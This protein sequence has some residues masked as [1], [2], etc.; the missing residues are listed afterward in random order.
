MLYRFKHD[1][2]NDP[3]IFEDNRLRPRSYFIPFSSREACDKCDY[4]NE[5][6]SSDCVQVL[7][8]EWDFVYYSK[9][10]DM[11]DK[12]DFYDLKTDKVQVPSCWQY[13]GYESP[14]YVNVRYQFDYKFP[15]V[16]ADE[17]TVG[18]NMP[19]NDGKIHK[20][21]NSIGV[22]RRR[23]EAK[24]GFKNFLTFLGAA[25]NVQVYLN[26]RY[27][28]YGEG[29]HN[30]SEFDVTQFML[31]GE[32]ELVVLVYKW[33]SGTYLESQDMF[34][35]NGIFRDVYLTTHYGAYIWDI[36]TSVSRKGAVWTLSAEADV[37]GENTSLEYVLERAGR[38]IA[39]VKA[40]AGKASFEIEQP[41]L[42][43]AE[44]PALYMLYA[45]LKKGSKTVE[46]IRQEVGFKEIA[47][48]GNVYLF[49]GKPI[50][51]KGVN[52]HDTDESKGYVMNAFDYLKDAMLMKEYNV[53]AV[54][55]SHYPPDPV[56]I[57]IA[58][59]IGLYIIDEAD[60]ETHGASARKNFYTPNAI[61]N[62]TPWKDF[63][64]DRVY[65]MYERDKNNPCVSMWSLGN[66][67]GGWRNQ[68]YC[69]AKLK[70]LTPIPIHYE[71]VVRTKR[72][73]Y[74][75][76]SEM[77]PS[78]EFIDKYADGTAPKKYYE[79]PY[80]MCEYAHAMG[81][82]PGS[83]DRY[84]QDIY[85]TRSAMGG[86]IW[87]WCD[88]AVKH[89]DGTYTYGGD[90]GEYDHD[91]NFC[92]DGLF[93][94]NRE[95]HTGARLMQA[96]YRPV[97]AAYVSSN[98]Y[99]LTN[100]NRFA[101][102]SYIDIAWQYSVDGAVC[103]SGRI[104]RIIAPA[105]TEEVELK[106]RAIDT[107]K[108]CCITFVYTD[109]NTGKTIAK[110]QIMM[111][112]SMMQLR[113]PAEK[114]DLA[115][116]ES[117]DDISVVTNTGRIKINK[118]DG[119]VESWVTAG[120]ELLN[121]NAEQKGF[122]LSL[123]GAP[124]DNYM[125]VDWHWKKAGFD[126]YKV[127]FVGMDSEKT[128]GRVVIAC[129]YKVMMKGRE[130]FGFIL[131]YTVRADNS[132]DV[133]TLLEPKKKYDLPKFG[134]TIEMPSA[135]DRVRYYGRGEY[136]NYPDMN[137]HAVLGI[138]KVSV[139]RMYENYIKPQESGSRGDTR[140]AEVT[141]ES[142]AGLR[143]IAEEK[144]FAFYAVPYTFKGI[145]GAKHRGDINFS[146]TTCVH[147]DGFVRGIGSNSC[148]PDARREFVKKDKE[149]LSYAFRVC[150]IVPETKDG[151]K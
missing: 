96:V 98:K 72:F 107:T 71:G 102:S 125:N 128:Y 104:D 80:F 139:A 122:R 97:I 48:D 129:R 111:C 57:K 148:G 142:G 88:H 76:I 1:K 121:R 95:P 124:I 5:R 65:R 17:S 67:A 146:G 10:G 7:S 58:N 136:E 90:H 83:L 112:Q 66:E 81:V 91:S 145:Y 2:F 19:T 108:D 29:S 150:P 85:K 15:Y 114:E 119:M 82:G 54:R 41:D 35:S 144:P 18:K 27:I 46:C 12:I 38:R 40:R 101:D 25:S 39:S 22:Y 20:V 103:E 14:Y 26:G 135:Y 3:K 84:W 87:E 30:T 62:H 24:R 11:P 34:R 52:H 89:K 100:T 74:D 53:N 140:W 68:D 151:G 75:V 64:W 77:Y 105:E 69:Y 86:C 21:Y 123:Y 93:F 9:I 13:T 116:I 70:R 23:F 8:G 31:D 132:M 141:D 149:S 55:T 92:V 117:Q 60:I 78:T 44:T 6:S 32:N 43:S 130:G 120:V 4:L 113:K 16:P 126:D 143:F 51:F 63:Y 59:Y 49:N 42:W 37:R 147:I 28:G 138:Y 134:L 36:V 99:A 73:A 61:S 33:C 79:K 47:I 133:K 50:K 56:F 110:E 131:Q 137:A 115:F 109:K 118:K 94:P 45:V 106:H 127:E